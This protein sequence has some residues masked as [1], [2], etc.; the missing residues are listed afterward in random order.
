MGKV[1][2]SSTTVSASANP[3]ATSPFS[4]RSLKQMLP[5]A[6]SWIR[7]APPATA[8]SM[9]TTAGRGSYST[10]TARSASSA[11]ASSSAATAATGWPAKSARSS[12]TMGWS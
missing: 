1:K 9:P 3:A 11:A 2:V 12:A 10:A 5:G 7:G 4:S 8:S 6:D